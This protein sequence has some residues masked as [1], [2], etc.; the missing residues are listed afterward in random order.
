MNAQNSK[1]VYFASF[2]SSLSKKAY[3]MVGTLIAYEW[4]LIYQ[5]IKLLSQLSKKLLSIYQNSW[6]ITLWTKLSKLLRIF[7]SS[8]N[9]IQSQRVEASFKPS[10]IF[11]CW[12]EAEIFEISPTS[13]FCFWGL[14]CV[15]KTYFP[16]ISR[17]FVRPQESNCWKV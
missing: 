3:N 10:F 12:V 8:L 13:T 14:Y 7:K 2:L 16:K 11:L 17:I 6:K 5:K 1:N 9:I 4:L 15:N